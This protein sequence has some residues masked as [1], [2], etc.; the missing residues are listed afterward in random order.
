VHFPF[1]ARSVSEGDHE[2]NVAA[3]RPRE[4][5]TNAN[6]RGPGYS[7]ARVPSWSPSLTLRARNALPLPVVDRPRVSGP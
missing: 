6:S 2:K 1:L 5:E 7:G 3:R 4:A